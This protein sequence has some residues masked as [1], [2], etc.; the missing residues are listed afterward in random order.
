MFQLNN[1]TVGVFCAA[2]I[3]VS[4]LYYNAVFCLFK[5]DALSV[6]QQGNRF[7][8]AVRGFTVHL[9]EAPGTGE[10]IVQM[11]GINGITFAG[12]F[13]PGSIQETFGD[14]GTVN[15]FAIDAEPAAHAA[16]FREAP[17]GEFAVGLGRYVQ[18]QITALGYNIDEG[19]YQCFC[20]LVIV[21]I[22]K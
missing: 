17:G 13:Y 16:Q 1:V 2:G 14:T 21:R 6:P 8:A 4:G 15:A 22:V 18:R 12:T 20:V 7:Y 19:M 9:E 5:G 11:K 3:D 10:V